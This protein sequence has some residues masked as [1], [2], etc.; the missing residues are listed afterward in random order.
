METRA[1]LA[2]L[3]VNEK[4]RGAE[5]GV[6]YGYF[7]EIMARDW[8]GKILCV[9]VWN[10]PHIYEEAKR[11]LATDQFFL[12]KE[13]SV[14]AAKLVEDESL[15]WVYIDGDHSYAGVK[16]DYE[17]WFPKVRKGGIVSGHDYGVNDCIGVKEFLDEFMAANPDIKINFTTG[18]FWQGR[19]Y[20][21]WWFVKE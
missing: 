9:D 3:F 8:K 14:E 18:D 17:A 5:I 20:Q 1:E 15:D 12:M 10:I 6:E 4:G 11:R 16:A 21:T 7:S 13:S 19:E 2:K